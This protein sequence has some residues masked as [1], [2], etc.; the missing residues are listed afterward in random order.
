MMTLLRMYR[1]AHHIHE[2][3]AMEHHLV[4]IQVSGTISK[5]DCLHQSIVPASLKHIMVLKGQCAQGK[6]TFWN[7]F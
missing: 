6:E 1:L 4:R 3:F 7:E 5:L 2:L